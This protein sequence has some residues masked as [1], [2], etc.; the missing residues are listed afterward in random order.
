M[1]AS[2]RSIT[3]EKENGRIYTPLSIVENILD[4]SGYYDKNIIKKHA[5]DNSCGDGAFLCEI[6]KRY[7]EASLEFGNSLSELRNDLQTYIH[8][9]EIDTIEHQRCIENVNKV[10][11]SFGLTEIDWD[12][13]CADTLTIHKYDGK[14]DFVLGNP[15]YVRVHNLG[16]S[17]SAIKSFSFA[18][19]GMTDLFIVFYELG[20]KML[21]A[22][23]TLGY[24][25]PSSF[26]NSLAGANMRKAFVE[27]H[28]LE[29]IVDLKHYQAFSATTYTTIVI[30][31]KSNSKHHT[32]Y[33]EYDTKN[34]IPYYVDSLESSDFYI[35]GNYFFAPKN[36]LIILKKVFF[37]YGK[38]DIAVKNGY[39]TLC[40]TV[41]IHDFDFE[42][43]YII[44]VVKA[45]KGTKKK[46]FFPY[47]TNGKLIP[48]EQIKKDYK[49]YDYLIK[50][51]GALTQR[52]HEKGDD[53]YWYSFGR[54]QA[55]N[56]TFKNKLTI[57]AIIR[58]ERD[59][60]FVEAPSGTGVYGG[61]Y[62]TS[63]TI[64]FSSIIEAIK[65][66]DFVDYIALLGKYKSGGYYTFSSKELKMYL[67]Y[68]F[69]Y[70]G[71]LLEC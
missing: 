47:G 36:N 20:I 43:E 38:C 63:E 15:P 26:F 69:N 17:F 40:D 3:A 31:K 25:T 62:I 60:K 4:L 34:G 58:D 30:L 55:I 28:Y 42:S 16:D 22:K 33:Y 39:A 37:N 6:I 18:Q 8:G 32:D 59:L 61:L 50:N 21:S 46:I 29:K 41:F 48:E 44:P 45:S 23:G 52:S 12:I 56:D 14:M 13:I 54:S 71:G 49:M 19:E 70:D 27:N 57:N 2:K 67:D 1:K 9:I 64:P 68:K 66:K 53:R 10:A 7:C 24:I 5:I 11:A 65:S 51:K 35:G